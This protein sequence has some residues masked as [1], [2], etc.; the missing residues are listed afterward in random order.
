MGGE[1]MLIRKLI[2]S[3]KPLKNYLSI[4]EIRKKLKRGELI[5]YE[6]DDIVYSSEIDCSTDWY[7]AIVHVKWGHIPLPLIPEELQLQI[8][9]TSEGQT[10][11]GRWIGERYDCEDDMSFSAYCLH[12]DKLGIL[13]SKASYTHYENINNPEFGIVKLFK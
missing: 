6:A 11:L 13:A 4:R 7:Y 12:M 9:A 8:L 2:R 3:Y 10:T 5:T 1:I